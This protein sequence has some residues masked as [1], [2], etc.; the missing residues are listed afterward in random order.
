MKSQPNGWML[1]IVFYTLICVNFTP[2]V[3]TYVLAQSDAGSSSIYES[4]FIVDMPTAGVLPKNTYCFDGTYFTNGGLLA[5]FTIAPLK[6][7]NLGISYS[8][9]NIIGSGDIKFQKWPGF[10][11]N[12]RIIDETRSIPAILIGANTQGRG[13]FISRKS[14]YVTLSPGIYASASKSFRWAIG[15]FSWHTGL[16][17]TF[18]QQAGQHTPNFWI[19]FEHSIGA[20]GAFYFELNP[21]LA[22]KDRQLSTASALLNIGTRW[23]IARG[24]TIELK[25]RDLLENSRIHLGIERWAGISYIRRF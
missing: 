7:L 5:S 15:S 23:S 17:Y 3:P 14:R 10:L 12:W 13:E 25:V 8:G 21:N 20:Y 2:F 1:R 16:N 4:R 6:N 22:D 9:S 18:E 24:V 11:L 19:G